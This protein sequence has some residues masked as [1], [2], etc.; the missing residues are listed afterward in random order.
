LITPTPASGRRVGTAAEGLA[1]EAEQVEDVV[2]DLAGADD[3][4]RIED[5]EAHGRVG[6]NA[7]SI[8]GRATS[9]RPGDQVGAV[10]R[11]PWQPTW[12]EP[13]ITGA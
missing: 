9:F 3:V 2:D 7:A 12:S 11:C 6:C 4:G 1:K 10:G 8:T 5:Q 13:A